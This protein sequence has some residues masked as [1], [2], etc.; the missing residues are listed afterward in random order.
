MCIR[1]RIS[2]MPLPIPFSEIFS[3]IHIT[4]MEPA[5]SE[6]T[7]VAIDQMCIRDSA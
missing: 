7:T 4:I 2:E 5:T 3:A 6:Q 1:D